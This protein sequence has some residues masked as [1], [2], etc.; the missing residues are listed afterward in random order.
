MTYD[1]Y[2][3]AEGAYYYNELG[4]AFDKDVFKG[5]SIY[6]VL[7]RDKVNIP[8]IKEFCTIEKLSSMRAPFFITIA[9]KIIP[10]TLGY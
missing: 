10:V 6:A 1:N 7:Y 3:I 5:T 2:L 9:D 4:F 8:F